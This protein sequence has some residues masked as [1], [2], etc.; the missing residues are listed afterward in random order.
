MAWQDSHFGLSYDRPI[1]TLSLNP[2]IPR[3]ANSRS[4]N[5]GYFETMCSI[6]S[7]IL[8]LLRSEVLEGNKIS[9]HVIPAYRRELDQII[10]DAAPRLRNR[11]DCVTTEDH[12][13]RLTLKLRSSYLISEICRRSLKPSSSGLPVKQKAATSHLC[14]ECIDSLVDT[15][16][17]FIDLHTLIPRGS[18]SWIFLHSAISAAFLLSVDEGAQVD[19]TVC[20]VLK[21]LEKVFED[22]VIGGGGDDYHL[23]NLQQQQ[24]QR[25]DS[26]TLSPE[27]TTTLPGSNIQSSSSSRQDL[28]GIGPV[29]LDKVFAMA[30]I[31]DPRQTFMLSDFPLSAES[32]MMNGRWID[33]DQG[34][35]G[36]GGGANNSFDPFSQQ[37]SSRTATEPDRSVQFLMSTLNS[38]RKINSEFKAQNAAVKSSSDGFVS[39]E[40][41]AGGCCMSRTDKRG[42]KAMSCH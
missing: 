36:G 24:Q 15:I 18:R 42:P 21:R 6:V 28:P 26:T 29:P 5:R 3:D 12:I 25:Q 38:L 22:L 33:D 8:Q 37:F 27:S 39:G 14:R 23:S 40:K 35:G 2:H 20:S 11:H 19:P 16:E 4:G 1:E 10:L 7:L 17:A 31:S 32:L 30:G 9:D 13:Q 34:G 41:R